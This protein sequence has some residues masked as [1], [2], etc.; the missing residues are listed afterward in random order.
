LLV[1]PTP[2]TPQDLEQF[3]SVTTALRFD[4]LLTPHATAD[5][6]L[7][8]MLTDHAFESFLAAQPIDLS[9][10]TD[11]RPFFFNVRRL[12]D[13]LDPAAWNT[14]PVFLLTALLGIVSL[15][16]LGCI[17]LP[18][19]MARPAERPL[20]HWPF[21]V[22]FAAIGAGFMSVEVAVMQQL[23]VFLGH[24]VYGLT[25]VLFTFLLSGGLGSLTVPAR[26]EAFRPAAFR[27]GALGFVLI[28][29][30]LGWPRLST[31]LVAA[32]TPVRLG[33]TVALLIPLG[34]FM[35][36][37][38]PLGMALAGPTAG[39]LAPWF[40]GMNGATSIVASVLAMIL[41]F[42]F[43]ISRAL[44]F[45]LGCYVIAGLALFLAW[46]QITDRPVA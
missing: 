17:L 27:L 12:S 3:A 15:L 1:S 10:P 14:G 45:G 34:F 28:A 20:A 41:A 44:W 13:V 40:W 39:S 37:P 46:R 5:P 21:L 2:F 24:P 22:F 23:M 43:G 29:V 42:G 19:W 9:P 31:A 30:L 7:E 11:D 35:G 33:V 18:L 16:T 26:F 6:F 25:V 8:A 4:P 32:S 36:M 38:F